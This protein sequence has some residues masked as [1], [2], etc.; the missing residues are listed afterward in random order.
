MGHP[1]SPHGA[2]RPYRHLLA[3]PLHG[4]SPFTALRYPLPA[5][6]VSRPPAPP[7]SPLFF[8]V[9]PA[10]PRRPA[11]GSFGST[12]GPAA[13]VS[14]RAGPR[15]QPRL[16]VPPPH[17]TGLISILPALRHAIGPS[18]PFV[19]ISER[20]GTRECEWVGGA[21]SIF[22]YRPRPQPRSTFTAGRRCGQCSDGADATELWTLPVPLGPP[23]LCAGS[24]P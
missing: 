10:L 24:R 1:G 2:P 16:P 22:A 15:R 12:P 4:A 18:F 8:A 11:P 9:L 21:M 20:E 17:L 23:P 5:G 3:A 19:C 14:S 7:S 6:P 13:P